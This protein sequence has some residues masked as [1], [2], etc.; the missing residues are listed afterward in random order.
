MSNFSEADA[1]ALFSAIRS[2]AKK[3]G[4]FNAVIGHDP[5]N[6]PPAGVN[7]SIMLGTVEPVAADSGLAAVSGQVTL[8]VHVW[9]FAN[10]KPL[11]D[12]DPKVLWATCA[13]MGA[14]AGGFTLNGTVRNI[15]LFAMKAQPG[16]TNF[17]GKEYRTMAI[18][19][20]IVIDDM[21]EELS[22]WPSSLDWVSDFWWAATIFPATFRRWNP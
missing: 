10:Q 16:Y 20:P 12:I 6:A 4:L 14:F 18:P 7:V 17:E 3:L 11:D 15:N 2:K 5:E 9:M 21:F 13:L 8:M 22:L 19:V 1:D